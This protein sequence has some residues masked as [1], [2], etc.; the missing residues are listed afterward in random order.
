MSA[1]EKN[2]RYRE[3]NRVRYRKLAAAQMR[4]YRAKHREHVLEYRRQYRIK[5]RE[6]MKAQRIAWVRLNP[7]KIKQYRRREARRLRKLGLTKNGKPIRKVLCALCKRP[8]KKPGS[9]QIYCGSTKN[10]KGC[11]YKMRL[12]KGRSNAKLSHQRKKL[13]KIKAMQEGGQMACDGKRY[14]ELGNKCVCQHK[15]SL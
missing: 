6:K 11:S 2:R 5:N 9:I 10:R 1:V 13:A 3:R 8:I 14:P 4:R 15:A 12:E 7:D